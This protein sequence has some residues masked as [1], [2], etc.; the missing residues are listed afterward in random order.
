MGR[1]RPPVLKDRKTTSVSIESKHFDFI[2][3]KNIDLS[4]LVRDTIDVLMQSEETPIEKL[5]RQKEEKEQEKRDMEIEISQLGKMIKEYEENKTMEEEVNKVVSELEEKRRNHLLEYKIN[6]KR[7]QTCSVLWLQH[8]KDGLKFATYEE[9]KM[10]ARDFWISEGLD[11]DTVT[12][13]LKLN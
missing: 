8:L 4:K 11:K 13:F 3:K 5:K 10:Y 9:A 1:G 2:L 7:K 6:V 12:S